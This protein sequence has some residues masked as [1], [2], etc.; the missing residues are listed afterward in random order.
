MVDVTDPAEIAQLGRDYS[1]LQP[2]VATIRDWQQAQ[3]D[4]AATREMLDDPDMRGLAEDEIAAIEARL[5]ALEEALRLALL[6]RDA[7]DGAAL[8]RIVLA[9]ELVLAQILENGEAIPV[10]QS[11]EL[12]AEISIHWSHPL[13]FRYFDNHR[14]YSR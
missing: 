13:S 10:G 7:A 11:L 1:G 6:P 14:N 5:P 3:A 2:V 4:L 9:G 8:S 12:L